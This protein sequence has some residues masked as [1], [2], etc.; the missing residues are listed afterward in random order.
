MRT[1][2]QTLILM[3]LCGYQLMAAEPPEQAIRDRLDAYHLA[4]RSGDLDG[5]LDMYAEDFVDPQGANKAVLEGFFRTLIEQGLLSGLEADM[6]ATD[7]SVEG[8]SATAGPVSYTTA[9]GTNS[10]AYRLR[11]DED[12]R[13][14]FV[15]SQQ[16]D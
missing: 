3:L 15:A 13:W 5:I 10:Y 4:E 8:L 14:R 6:S 1:L 7:I 16:L 12:G 2:L 9:L 11:K